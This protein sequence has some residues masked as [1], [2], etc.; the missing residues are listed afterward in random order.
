[1]GDFTIH[2]DSFVEC[3]HHLTLVLRRCIETNLVLNF[4]VSFHGAAWG[5]TWTCSVIEGIRGR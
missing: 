1:M 5:S 3:L 2:A 4:E